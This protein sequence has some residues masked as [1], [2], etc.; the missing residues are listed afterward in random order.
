ML[1]AVTE[2]NTRAQIDQLVASLDRAHRAA[3]WT[4]A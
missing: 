1:L 4:V 2:L 3:G